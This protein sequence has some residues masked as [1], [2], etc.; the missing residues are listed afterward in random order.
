MIDKG[1][2]LTG[3][4]CCSM[5]G[6]GCKRCPYNKDCDEMP[7]YGNAYLCSDAMELLNEQQETIVSLQ[8]TI[9]KLTKALAEKPEQKFFVDSDGKITPLPVQKHGYWVPIKSP[10][11]VEYGGIKEYTVRE[12]MCSE[13][14]FTDDV[15]ASIYTYCP[16]CGAKMDEKVMQDGET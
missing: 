10:T 8:S 4:E 12:V 5:N 13:C 9:N 1:K 7:D 16:E 3:L 6:N 2:V 11:G 14:G 15:S